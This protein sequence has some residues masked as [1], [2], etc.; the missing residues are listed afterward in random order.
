MYMHMYATLCMC[1]CM[2]MK[3]CNRH[4][5]AE[6]Q[7]AKRETAV[8]LG[9]P[10]PTKPPAAAAQPPSAAGAQPPSGPSPLPTAHLERG[11]ASDSASNQGAGKVAG[12]D[13]AAC[14]AVEHS[15]TQPS[16]PSGPAAPSRA[17]V[18]RRRAKQ[19]KALAG[20]T[21]AGAGGEP[22]ASADPAARSRPDAATS[23]NASSCGPCGLLAFTL[24]VLVVTNACSFTLA[25]LVHAG[26]AGG[27]HR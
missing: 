5:T 25:A 9:L 20:V 21:E 3:A 16:Q 19:A 8:H 22:G 17:K 24:G 11:C 7:A 18:R 26:P 27:E 12:Q 13:S 4:V 6:A 14:G 23:V 2:C 10:K 1:M 15:A